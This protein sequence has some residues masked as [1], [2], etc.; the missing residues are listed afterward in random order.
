MTALCAAARK[1]L[2]PPR[3]GAP[4]LHSCLHHAAAPG[5]ERLRQDRRTPGGSGQRCSRVPGDGPR[6]D[7]WR[8]G[9]RR[10]GGP[11]P[12]TSRRR[13]AGG[14]AGP[15][16]AQPRVHATTDSPEP[17]GGPT[18]RDR[19]PRRPSRRRSRLWDARCRGP[20][21]ASHKSN[22]P[23]RHG[24]SRPVYGTRTAV[25]SS[26]WRVRISETGR[27]R[28]LRVTPAGRRGQRFPGPGRGSSGPP[29]ATSAPTP[30]HAPH[31][32][33]DFTWRNDS[34]SASADVRESRDHHGGGLRPPT[35]PALHQDPFTGL[36]QYRS[37]AT[38][39]RRFRRPNG[40]RAPL[41]GA[42]RRW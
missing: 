28:C 3:P 1:R 31:A 24:A 29:C 39:I 25:R 41:T 16:G 12:S 26:E 40:L 9:H 2:S 18:Y 17:E 27:P 30:R 21:D 15:V 36:D 11:T 4:V 23:G 34:A 22:G 20:F 42:D 8:A 10:G 13:S 14:Q 6:A 7:S 5:P 38:P 35:V 32:R 33:R 19:L 37:E